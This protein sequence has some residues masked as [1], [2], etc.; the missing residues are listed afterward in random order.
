MMSTP[1]L[2]YP[3]TGIL[4]MHNIVKRP[5]V[6]GDEVEIRPMMYVALS[7]TTASST[8]ARPCRS[9][10]RQGAPRG[11]RADAPRGLMRGSWARRS[12]AAVALAAAG[13]SAKEPSLAELSGDVTVVS[14]WATTCKPCRNEMPWLETLR[15]SLAADARVRVVAVNIDEPKD[16]AAAR[17]MATELGLTAPVLVDAKL[18]QRFFGG[19]DLAVPRL[20]VI[21]KKLAGLERL[22]ALAGEKGDGFVRDVSAAVAAVE[23]GGSPSPP[24]AMWQPFRAHA[25]R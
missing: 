15:K 25:R 8:G 18:Y 13:A 21:D 5:M 12:L 17:A 19:K 4:G 11:A 7:T 6:V 14:F 20:V 24:S 1:L 10:S 16:A 3:Q 2:N 22:G 23:G 9:S